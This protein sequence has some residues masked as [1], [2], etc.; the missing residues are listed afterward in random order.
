MHQQIS[1]REKKIANHLSIHIS[2]ETYLSIYLST[3]KLLYI[4]HPLCSPPPA[5]ISQT[6]HTCPTLVMGYRA[7]PPPTLSPRERRGEFT[8]DSRKLLTCRKLNHI[9][10]LHIRTSCLFMNS[11]DRQTDRQTV[12]LMDVTDKTQIHAVNSD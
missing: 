2:L 3:T 8:L 11:I 7:P 9:N 4:A 1:L 5:P 12:L 6:R 10:R